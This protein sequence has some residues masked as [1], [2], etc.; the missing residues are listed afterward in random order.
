LNL[1]CH[2]CCHTEGRHAQNL[3]RAVFPHNK[4]SFWVIKKYSKA[5]LGIFYLKRK[6]FVFLASIT[7]L[8][9]KRGFSEGIS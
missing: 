8:L 3:A 7:F 9:N 2:Q 6:F 5:N 4:A 1:G